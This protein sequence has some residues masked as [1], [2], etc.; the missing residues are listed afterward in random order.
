MAV[1]INNTYKFYKNIFYKKGLFKSVVGLQDDLDLQYN[2]LLKNRLNSD[3]SF[4]QEYH[5]NVFTG[6]NSESYDV[7]W[8]IP[9][10]EY[11]IKNKKVPCVDINLNNLYSDFNNLEY[12][13]LNHYKN[14][15]SFEPIIV[16]YYLPIKR[17]IVIDGNHRV[18]LSNVKG[19]KSIRA[20]ILS[21][22]LNLEIMN[23]KNFHLYVF[24]HN[25]V[26][27]L[28][29]CWNP[30]EWKFKADKS[31]SWNTYYGNVEFKNLIFNK[32]KMI[33]KKPYLPKVR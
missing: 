21:P 33:I 19:E 2:R 4:I 28:N 26:N 1:K 14:I 6:I 5:F 22:F 17:L 7:S 11:L 18:Y 3:I 8:S 16:S 13:K 29:L 24:H 10:A 30:L 32:M 27:L 15:D 31:L 20:F 12:H 9:K 23:E 25:L